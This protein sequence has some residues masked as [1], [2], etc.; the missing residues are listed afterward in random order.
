MYPVQ[1]TIVMIL[2]FC[3]RT[4]NQYFDYIQIGSLKKLQVHSSS[5]ILNNWDGG[6]ENYFMT[7]FLII[8]ILCATN[9]RILNCDPFLVSIIDVRLRPISLKDRDYNCL[10][11]ENYR[12]VAIHMKHPLLQPQP[13]RNK[14]IILCSCWLVDN[15][16]TSRMLIIGLKLV[17]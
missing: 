13:H 2:E 5:V 7:S 4:S 17:K 3:I 6:P 10:W 1:I 14:N 11:S 9:R 16:L 8:F 12:P 15:Y